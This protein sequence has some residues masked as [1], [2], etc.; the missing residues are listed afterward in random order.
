MYKLVDKASSIIV[1]M[2][3]SSACV[4]NLYSLNVREYEVQYRSLVTAYSLLEKMIEDIGVAR[5][6]HEAE[7]G[8]LGMLIE[9]FLIENKVYNFTVVDVE[10][11]DGRLIVGGGTL[12]GA[13]AET[14]LFK[15]RSRLVLKVWFKEG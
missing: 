5:L 3:I 14:V 9:R 13:P 15:N 7:R 12:S 11:M 4:N 10:F 1:V 6:F 8:S 2:I